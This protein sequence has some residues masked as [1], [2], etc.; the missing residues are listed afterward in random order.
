[1]FKVTTKPENQSYL[2]PVKV[3]LPT[4]T[5]VQTVSFKAR[6]K[7]VSQ[8]ELDDFR[9]RLEGDDFTD[10][11]LVHEVMCGWEGVTDEEGATLDFNP[12]NLN[13][14]LNMYPT[15]P[16]I[17]KTFYDSIKGAKRKN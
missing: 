4:E 5:G 10:R 13:A 6:F 7:R 8:E 14:L 9:D 1:M 3:D 12:D 2:W 17:V 15:R 11:E 16:T